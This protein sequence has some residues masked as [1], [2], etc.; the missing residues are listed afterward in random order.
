MLEIP[1][2]PAW[3][4]GFLFALYYIGLFFEARCDRRRNEEAAKALRELLAM[5]KEKGKR[6]KASRD[7][8]S[9]WLSVPPY[10]G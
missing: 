3:L 10:V 7:T 2:H 8:L 5:S 9:C 6:G 4:V 1:I